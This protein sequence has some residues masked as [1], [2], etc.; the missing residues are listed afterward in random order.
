MTMTNHQLDLRLAFTILAS[1]T[2]FLVGCSSEVAD[3]APSTAQMDVSEQAAQV[4]TSSPSEQ[5]NAL[6]E[7]LF[8]ET[9]MLHPE[10]QTFL[11][12][13]TNYDKWNDLSAEFRDSLHELT[14]DQ[15]QRLQQL[16]SD[17]LA[18]Q[19]LLSYQLYEQQLKNSIDDHRWRDH[20]YPVNQMFGT[21]AGIPSL[22]INQHL[23]ESVEDAEAYIAR[24]NGVP[25]VIDQLIEGLAN[26]AEKGIVAPEFVFPHV[27]ESSSNIIKGIGEEQV[28]KSNELFADFETKVANLEL[29]EEESQRLMADISNALSSSLAPA[30]EKLIAYLEELAELADGN[31]GV[32]ALPDGEAYYENRLKR[33]TTTDFTAEEIHQIGL[34]EVERI[35]NEMRDIMQRVNFEGSLKDFFDFTR[36]D[37]QFFYDNTDEGRAAYLAEATRVIDDMKTRLDE[38]FYIKPQADLVVKAVEPFREKSAGIAFYQRPA[39]NGSRPGIYYANLYKMEDMAKYE[40][41]A[42][43]YHEGLPGHHMQLAI[44]QEQQQMPKF[45]RFGGYTAY[46]EGWGLYSEYIPKEMGLYQDPYSDFGRLSMELWRAARLV[47]DTGLHYKRWTREQAIEYLN[48]NT[49]SSENTNVKAIERYLVMPAQATAY[50]IGMMKILELREKAREALGEQFDIRAYHDLVLANG[51]VPLNVLEDLVDDWIEDLGKS[52]W[53]LQEG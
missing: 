25:G 1:I 21:H 3:P 15:L 19:T 50:K 31:H 49:P 34:A 30:Y 4:E 14:Q 11:G 39:P 52:Y 42:L 16:N 22:L 5:A 45:R 13:K 23:I 32:W 6:Y 33:M 36:V 46:I 9:L 2:F 29:S 18:G 27:L 43:A 38:L 28:D 10:W 12:M 51:A 44:A 7:E 17:E 40:L 53:P 48:E 35:H 20:G 8:N 37:E 26:R 47:V 24:V 41:E